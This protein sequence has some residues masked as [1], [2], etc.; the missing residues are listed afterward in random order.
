M[1]ALPV[2]RK[3]TALLSNYL[4]SAPF[5]SLRPTIS[6][7]WNHL[8]LIFKG[9][10]STI[11]QNYYIIITYCLSR[12]IR[13]PLHQNQNIRAE[14]D[15]AFVFGSIDIGGGLTRHIYGKPYIVSQAI[16][17]D[18]IDSDNEAVDNDSTMVLLN[19]KT[20]L[21][22]GLTSVPNFKDLLSSSTYT[23]ELHNEK[24]SSRVFSEAFVAE[25]NQALSRDAG[26]G[27]GAKKKDVKSPTAKKAPTGDK[28]VGDKKTSTK[29]I[30]DIVPSGTM[31][32]ADRWL[33]QSLASAL[34]L[35][36]T[37]SPHGVA[38]YRLEQ[39]LTSSAELL[40]KFQNKR[41]QLASSSAIDPD[42]NHVVMRED[43]VTDVRLEKAA[44]PLP[45]HRPSDI[46][47]RKALEKEAM[48]DQSLVKSITWKTSQLPFY[49]MFIKSETQIT[50][51]V[52]MHKFLYPPRPP[53]PPPREPEAD[54]PPSTK[55]TTRKSPRKGQTVKEEPVQEAPV[56][57]EPVVIPTKV[58]TPQELEEEFLQ[59]KLK[60]TP[61]ARMVFVFRYDDDETLMRIND[62][63]EAVNMRALP[64][65]QGS[66]QSYKLAAD[67]LE[68]CRT[69]Q[70]DLI[71]GFM[72]I[73]DIRR[74]I[75]VEG[76]ARPGGGME[77]L[78]LN[79]PR[80]KPN[81]DKLK[82]LCNPEVLFPDRLYP[83]Y[84]PDLRRIRLRY[85]LKK[86]MSKFELY[87]RKQV[88]EI[89]FVGLDMLTSLIRAENLVVTKQLDLYPPQPS[90]D[91]LELLYGEAISRQDIV[92]IYLEKQRMERVRQERL[93][94]KA[95]H[96]DLS[97]DSNVEEVTGPAPIQGVY[98]THRLPPTDCRNE[99]FEAYLKSRPQHRIDYLRENNT[100]RR[101]VWRHFLLQKETKKQ[102]DREFIEAV[103]G[104]S[105]SQIFIYS[106]QTL[107]IKNLALQ[108]LKQKLS[109]IPNSTF[110]YSKDYVSQTISFD[111]MTEVDYSNVKTLAATHRQKESSWLTPGGFQYP[112]PKTIKDLLTH[113]KRPT[114][115]RIEDL[116]EPWQNDLFP[117]IG[118]NVI[119][120]TAP[121]I[122]D[123]ERNYQLRFKSLDELGMLHPPEF[124]HEFQLNLVGSRTE[125]PRGKI[126]GGHTRD[127]NFFHSIHVTG[128]KKAQILKE[129]AEKE[130]QLWK[131]KVI[132]DHE[133]FKV[134][135]F[136]V[137]DQPSQTDRLKG[138]LHDEPKTFAL[139]KLRSLKSSTGKDFSYSIAPLSILSVEPYTENPATL[140]LRKA[141]KTKFIT[142]TNGAE[143]KDFIG[144]I[145][146]DASAPRVTK[147]ISKRSHLPLDR[148]SAECSGPKWEAAN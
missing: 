27:K 125:L 84:G 49:E 28:K 12:V 130:K 109:K 4:Q 124:E 20:C 122:R 25:Y 107:S 120:A 7:H 29:K 86:L 90:L 31:T 18:D 39:L 116:K 119:L 96:A 19:L 60:A 63:I 78:F 140:S 36:R 54:R 83:S 46:S 99:S 61:F 106:N 118:S 55:A 114:E 112:K 127:E 38:S 42:D 82:M 68:S 58:L 21:L 91:K 57:L 76:L 30:A 53:S 14:L 23:L 148:S 50:M 16:E 65:I 33:V 131:S 43:M 143:P 92:G 32:E 47:L 48:K 126:V 93:A 62:A 138:I 87:D 102:A 136:L 111:N 144:Y 134:D 11:L 2:V 94:V 147:L 6:F 45:W 85:R 104:S 89:C 8:K 71:T 79:L 123:R 95:K 64:D 101:N 128:D 137:K 132:V 17:N 34:R 35:S 98:R 37:L 145:P 141:D 66:I 59:Q 67:E 100:I 115:T 113:P 133:D 139:K 74:I 22:P 52:Q 9:I 121:E 129:A 51:S 80:E 73:D 75:V 24:L 41:K 103:T 135:G 26:G 10:I 88:D 77:F 110:S 1:N 56:V 44:K 108:K 13:Y 5:L 97:S 72:I 40:L 105:N 117:P 142:A 70:L 15:K 69:A 146:V 81:D 3:S